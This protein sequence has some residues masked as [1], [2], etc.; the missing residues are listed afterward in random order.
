[1]TIT[2]NQIDILESLILEGEIDLKS[3]PKVKHDFIVKVKNE[4]KNICM[5]N[6]ESFPGWLEI[7]IPPVHIGNEKLTEENRLS[8][9][10]ELFSHILCM[11]RELQSQY[12]MRKQLVESE[13]QTHEA[14]RQTQEA[15][16]QTKEAHEANRKT[17]IA[18]TISS[19]AVIVSIFA[20]CLSTCTRT[21]KVEDA[22]YKE[23][24]KYIEYEA[25]NT[26]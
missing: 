9:Y 15:K 5:E 21:I 7:T 25:S 22:Q 14:V 20:V 11:L 16:K 10:P 13:K 8:Y 19:F 4:I 26:N 2:D 1:M 17:C 6:E 12:Y 24:K 3:L 18:L 23:I